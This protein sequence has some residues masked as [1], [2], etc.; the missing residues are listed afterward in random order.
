M[1]KEKKRAVQF[2]LQL[3]IGITLSYVSSSVS[4]TYQDVKSVLGATHLGK[5]RKKYHYQVENFCELQK[6]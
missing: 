4:L 2:Q 6:Q 1:G 3:H 5:E